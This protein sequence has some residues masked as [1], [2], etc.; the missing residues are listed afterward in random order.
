MSRRQTLARRRQRV[1]AP[2][3]RAS[4][5]SCG[6]RRL[7]VSMR[8]DKHLSARFKR[9]RL[10]RLASSKTAMHICICEKICTAIDAQVRPQARNRNDRFPVDS[11]QAR[12]CCAV[13]LED[14]NEDRRIRDDKRITVG[15]IG[16]RPCSAYQERCRDMVD[17]SEA[18]T[19]EGVMPGPERRLPLGFCEQH[20]FKKINGLKSPALLSRAQSPA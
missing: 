10:L 20:V 8:P 1:S 12:L 5:A 15:I 3:S 14:R 16:P 7:C 11:Q 6:A 13:P 4:C 2:G 18:P 9:I 19:S 17:A